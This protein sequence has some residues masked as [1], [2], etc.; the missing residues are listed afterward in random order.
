MTRAF[1][2]PTRR[3]RVRQPL[4][5]PLQAPLWFRGDDGA[6][7]VSFTVAT[8]AVVAGAGAGGAIAIAAVA[9]IRWAIPL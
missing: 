2:P 8:A 3:L 1:A 9:T 6:I 4:S 5:L 7:R